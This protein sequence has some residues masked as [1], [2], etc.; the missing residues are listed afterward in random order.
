M[1]LDSSAQLPAIAKRANFSIF[2]INP[3]EAETLL[4]KTYKTQALF[5]KPDPKT[6]KISVEMVRDFTALTDSK[7]K[8]HRFFVV[9][10]AET[11]NP[12]AQN[13]FLKNLEELQASHHFILITKTPSAL[14]PTILSRA[15]VFYL[16]ETNALTS[17]VSADETTKTLA[18][19][20]ISAN[21]PKLLEL[22]T[23]ISKKKDNP[24]AYALAITSA[25]IEILYKSYFATN[26]QKFLKKL[27]NLLKLHE[28]LTAGG[29]IKLHIV[30]DML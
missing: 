4:S 7:D 1:F 13:A 14:L 24:R 18:K 8:S 26:Q 11:L 9:L 17:P 27:P 19:R 3:A 28:N 30:A 29:H 25:A 12:V 16:R 5:L 21:V 22:S 23:E 20:L 15:Q 2:A 6:L 10:N